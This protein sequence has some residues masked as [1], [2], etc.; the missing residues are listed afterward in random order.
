MMS[1]IRNNRVKSKAKTAVV[2]LQGQ[3]AGF[4]KRMVEKGFKCNDL[5]SPVSI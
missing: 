1:V 2:G 5:R 3:G 4:S